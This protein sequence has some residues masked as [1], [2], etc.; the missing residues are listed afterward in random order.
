MNRR[1]LIEKVALGSAVLVLAPSIL[2]SCKTKTSTTSGE[3]SPAASGSDQ[4]G[5]QF[6]AAP[7]QINLDLTMPENLSLAN[8]G[9]SKLVK[10]LIIINSGNDNFVALSSICTHEG[11]TVGYDSTSGNIKCPCHGAQFT[12]SGSI[13]SGPVGTPL[14]SFPITKSNNILTIS[15]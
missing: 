9:G 11:C 3:N 10:D 2:Q 14:K 8:A 4:S 15:L 7:A 12:T 13:I 5:A 1:E 6:S